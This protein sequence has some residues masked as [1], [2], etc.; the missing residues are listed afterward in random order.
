MHF[1]VVR[2]GIWQQS[3]FTQQL[4]RR[5]CILQWCERE[6]G[7]IHICTAVKKQIVRFVVVRMSGSFVKLLSQLI[8]PYLS[9]MYLLSYIRLALLVLLRQSIEHTYTLKAL[10]QINTMS[11]VQLV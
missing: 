4:R 10:P 6:C 3:A 2:S 1:A 11:L 7:S 5:S 9:H 8:E